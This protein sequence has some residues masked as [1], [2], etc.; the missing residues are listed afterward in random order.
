MLLKLASAGER[1]RHEIISL[2]GMGDLGAE[3]LAR[4]IPLETLSIHRPLQLPSTLWRLREELKR[5]SDAVI[6]A[7]MNHAM[8]LATLAHRSASLRSPL[9]WNVRQS[10]GDMKCETRTTRA[11]IRINARLSHHADRIIYNS[12]AG[13]ADHEAIGFASDRKLLIGNG[14]DLA[15]FR[16]DRPD[17]DR[18]RAQLGIGANEVVFGFFAR[19][20]SIKNHGAFIKA[21]EQLHGRYPQLRLLF[22]GLDADL[23]LPAFRAL[24]QDRSLAERTIA[25]GLRCDVSRLTRAAD[26]AVNVSFQEGFS[27]AIGE[28][29]AS[30][31]PCLV[32][33]AGQSAALVSSTGIVC[34]DF[35]S[36][37]IAEGMRSFLEMSPEERARLGKA[38]RALIDRNYSV[39]AIVKQFERA[40]DEASTSRHCPG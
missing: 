6:V 9:I 28:A 22:V 24:F 37:A 5:A 13:Q 32:T 19:V 26:V 36:G 18:V 31:V 34:K 25:L 1:Y 35:T 12:A 7:W 2:A 15:T 39:A 20:H 21:A 11:I 30:A 14:F 33:D 4:G 17:R 23:R 3:V 40:F 16:P 38:A 29:M 8:L 27:N 10:L